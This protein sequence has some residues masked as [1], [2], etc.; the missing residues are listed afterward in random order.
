MIDWLLNDIWGW[1]RKGADVLIVV[2]L[3]TRLAYTIDCP[4][5]A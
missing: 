4:H 1:E 5:D 3:W 2:F